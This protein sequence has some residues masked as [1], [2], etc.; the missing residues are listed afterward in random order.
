M[1]IQIRPITDS[2]I[3]GY[4]R[5]VDQVAREKSFL[6]VS[7]AFTLA[8]T[9]AFVE[10]NI[11]NNYP[12]YVASNVDDVVGWCDIIPKRKNSFHAHEGRLGMGLLADF[13]HQGIG[14]RLLQT[15]LQS[16]VAFGLTRIELGVWASNINAIALYKKFGFEMEGRHRNAIRVDGRFFDLLTMALLKDG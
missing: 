6:S 12:H 3:I 5:A 9:K 1:N 7:E 2:D 10:N 15:T 14:S 4:H 8:E 13:R 16:A 11:A